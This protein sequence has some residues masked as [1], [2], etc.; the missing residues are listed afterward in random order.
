MDKLYRKYSTFLDGRKHILSFVGAGGK[1]TVMYE[2][3]EFFAAAGKKVL[4]STTTHIFK[5]DTGYYAEDREQVSKLWRKGSYA[6]IGTETPDNK[7]TANEPLMRQLADEAE[8]ILLEADGAKRFPCKVPA[9][10]EPVLLDISDIVIGVFGMDA[11]GRELQHCC[12]RLPQAKTL[13]QAEVD[14]IL[15]EADAAKIL[16][17]ASGTRKNIGSRRYYIVLNKCDDKVLFEQ[18]EK[19]KKLIDKAVVAEDDIWLR[20][21]GCSE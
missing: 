8:L 11:V 1:S 16:M 19:I 10:H 5:P 15:T 3:A 4:V 18:A 17:S 2:M 21:A 12:F 20:G 6:V 13:L 14:H 7:L 9:E